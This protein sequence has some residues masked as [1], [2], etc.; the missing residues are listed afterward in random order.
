MLASVLVTGSDQRSCVAGIAVASSG[1]GWM[2]VLRLGGVLVDVCGVGQVLAVK[3]Y[4]EPLVM[5]AS[6]VV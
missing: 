1:G 5:G 6:S 3:L 4:Q 2:R